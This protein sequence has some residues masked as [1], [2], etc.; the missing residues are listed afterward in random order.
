MAQNEEAAAAAALELGPSA[1]QQEE[2]TLFR[3]R[4]FPGWG[5]AGPVAVEQD[6]EADEVGNE[7]NVAPSE[8][9]SG[10]RQGTLATGAVLASLA[11]ALC[12]ACKLCLSCVLK[13]LK[14]A[15]HALLCMLSA[16]F[17]RSL[18]LAVRPCASCSYILPIR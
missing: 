18:E 15:V 10:G 5:T 8:A 16:S 12:C 17:L 13:E 6:E 7:E 11:G 1:R 9:R 4:S 3:R 14:L 2:G